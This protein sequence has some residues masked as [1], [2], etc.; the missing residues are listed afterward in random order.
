MENKIKFYRNRNKITQ[1]KL[2]DAVSLT[3]Q[4]ISNLETQKYESTVIIALKIARFF[5]VSVEDIFILEDDELIRYSEIPHRD[6]AN[7]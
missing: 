6:P 3:R 2:G 7:S 5:K 1:Q 4:G